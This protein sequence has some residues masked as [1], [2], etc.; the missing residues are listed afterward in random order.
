VTALPG[1]TPRS[2]PMV[3]G[4][5]LVT[6]EPA[7]TAKLVAVPRPTGAWAALARGAPVSTSANDAVSSTPR[8]PRG[9]RTAV[10]RLRPP[11]ERARA[12]WT[13]IE[14][15]SGFGV[16]TAHAARPRS[17]GSATVLTLA[18]GPGANAMR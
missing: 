13:F 11:S 18:Q 17:R 5:V 15:P 3:L 8:T 2:P 4:P 10:R 16:G 7:S 9:A 14:N 6:V 1:L 12:K